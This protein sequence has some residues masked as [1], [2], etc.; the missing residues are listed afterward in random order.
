MKPMQAGDAKLFAHLAEFNS[1]PEGV[2]VWAV[3]LLGA[4]P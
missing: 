1:M 2:C 4:A 3:G